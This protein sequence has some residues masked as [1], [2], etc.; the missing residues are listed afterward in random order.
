MDKCKRL[1]H[2][3]KDHF[4]N[5]SVNQHNCQNGLEAPPPSWLPSPSCPQG[6][7]WGAAS[8]TPASWSFQSSWRW[9]MPTPGWGRIQ[10]KQE[11]QKSASRSLS[12]S[13]DVVPGMAIIALDW[14]RIIATIT[15]TGSVEWWTCHQWKLVGRWS[16]FED[17]PG[18]RFGLMC[19]SRTWPGMILDQSLRWHWC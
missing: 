19:S 1:G 3:I 7:A 5:A 18:Q 14:K 9:S 6:S 15:K 10:L 16:S 4:A 11:N 13:D 2:K 8:V 17:E 12:L